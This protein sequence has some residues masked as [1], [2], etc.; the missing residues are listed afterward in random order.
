[1][2]VRNAVVAE[3]LL[4]VGAHLGADPRANIFSNLFPVLVEEAYC[5]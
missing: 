4:G 3:D 5:Y 1:M 2:P